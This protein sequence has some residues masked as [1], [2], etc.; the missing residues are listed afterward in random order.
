L[1]VVT[2]A[3]GRIGTFYRR[4]LHE[5]GQ[6][7]R[8]DRQLTLRLVDVR[9]PEGVPAGDEVLAGPEEA[10]LADPEV[11]RRAVAGATAVLH[12]A[13]DPS[14]R[15]DFY[16]SLL[17]RNVKAP[18]NVLQAAVEAGVRRV[19]LCSS[20]NAV[21]GYPRE[22][23]VRASDVAFPGNIYGATKAF[24]EALA[25]AFVSLH[26][27]FSAIAVRIGGVRHPD[28]M[29]ARPTSRFE[30]PPPSPRPAPEQSGATVRPGM[31]LDDARSVV[32][33]LPDLSRLFDCCLG[34]GPEVTFA[35]VNGSSRN[36]HL[37][38]D[39]EET[40]RLVGYEPQDDAFADWSPPE[41][42][43]AP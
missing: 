32:V 31:N 42:A 30:A 29:R 23:Q 22:R 14:P 40:R 20:I 18:Y 37:R 36:R 2:G 39:L 8:C 11:A 24:S 27:G 35:V 1:L 19:I 12:L 28:Q 15:A 43:P 4:W 26:P 38:M 17:D 10:D 13:A 5:G 7:G 21:N 25:G 9:P 34:A 41:T 3:S 16:G 33:T 6:V